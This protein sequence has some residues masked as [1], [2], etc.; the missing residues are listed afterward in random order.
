MGA[1]SIISLSIAKKQVFSSKVYVSKR[2][3]Y[4][5]VH[6]AQMYTC[7][8]VHPI[9][10]LSVADLLLSILWTLGGGAW[11]RRLGDR[12]WCYAISLPTIAS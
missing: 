4:K 7:L 2:L 9:F 5:S 1:I 8:Q 3:Q 6:W 12:V 11:L 10:M